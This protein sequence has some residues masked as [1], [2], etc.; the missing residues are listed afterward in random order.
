MMGRT[1]LLLGFGALLVL[2]LVLSQIEL[3]FVPRSPAIPTTPCTSREALM[4]AE[5]H[6]KEL[7]VRS[8]FCIG[9]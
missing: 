9:I 8:L 2:G 1:G 5:L 4:I 7:E 6:S 3:G